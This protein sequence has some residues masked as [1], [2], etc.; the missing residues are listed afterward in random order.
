MHAC[1]DVVV[2]GAGLAGLRA[3]Q[4]AR[5]AGWRGGV[6]L[7]G[8]EDHD[9]YDRPPLSKHLLLPAG[10]PGAL[11][12]LPRLHDASALRE[13]LGVDVRP[14]CRA[15]GLDIADSVVHTTAGPVP[16]GRLVIATGADVRA[17]PEGIGG[18]HTQALRSFEDARAVAEGLDRGGHIV[19]IGAGFIGSEVASAA[20]ARG[21]AVTVLEQASAPLVRSLGEQVEHCARTCTHVTAPRC[22][23]G[24]AWSRY[25]P[26]RRCRPAPRDATRSPSPTDPSSSPI[27]SSPGSARIRRRRGCAGQG[28]P[29]RA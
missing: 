28:G 18:A 20:R 21:L 4:S 1:D 10:A 19:V 27:S 29:A 23:W 26:W 3:C 14:R 7:L 5:R 25:G 8:A 22:G 16:F 9:P 6:R 13:D 15:V 11:S 2:V 17:L 24:S 12:E